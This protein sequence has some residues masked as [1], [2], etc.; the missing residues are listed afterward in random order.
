M[1]TLRTYTMG[2][3][4]TSQASIPQFISRELQAISS[5]IGSIVQNCPVSASFSD[6]YL[7]LKLPSGTYK[8]AAEKL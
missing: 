2:G 7:T 8:I 5:V 6:G 3:I 4:F 1:P